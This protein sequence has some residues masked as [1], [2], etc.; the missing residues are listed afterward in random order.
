MLLLGVAQ[1]SFYM[2][3]INLKCLHRK[4]KLRLLNT[5]GVSCKVSDTTIEDIEKFI[6]TVCYLGR[7]QESLTETRLQVNKMSQE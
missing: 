6:Q 5:V 2:L 3:L 7:E 1:L 4:E